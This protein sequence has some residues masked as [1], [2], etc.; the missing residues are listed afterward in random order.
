MIDVN[1]VIFAYGNNDVFS[2]HGNNRFVSVVSFIPNNSSSF[3]E[4]QWKTAVFT[5][6]FEVTFR[7]LEINNFY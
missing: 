4:S 2:Y 3:N 6:T 5:G 1:K 7:Y